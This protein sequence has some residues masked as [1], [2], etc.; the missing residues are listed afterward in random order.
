MNK[1]I[2]NHD[3]LYKLMKFTFGLL[4][5]VLCHSG[6]IYAK[7]DA[8]Y[9]RACKN[10]KDDNLPVAITGKVTD[11]K[12]QPLV[13]VSILIK[14]TNNG[15]VTDIDGK[16]KLNVLNEKAVLLFRYIGYINKEVVVGNASLLNVMLIAEPKSINEIVVVGYST[17]SKHKL[18][19]A[20]VTVSGDELNK[21]VATSP[22]T[23]LQGKLPGLQVVQGSGEPGAE[24]VQLTI[25]GTG[26]FSGA[27]S[28]P[29][30]IVDGLPGSLDVLNAN[31]IESISVLKDASSA[32]I[33]GS[34][35][36]NGVIVV[37][38]KRGKAGS[39]SVQ[40]AYN[41]GISNAT[42]LPDIVTNSATYMQ[43]SNEARTNSS[44]AP[45]YTQAQ[46]D[47]YQNATD[48]V[49]YPNHN[50]LND[51][52]RTAYTQNHYLN[53][54]GGKDSTTY[55]VGIGIT[56]QPGVMRGFDYKKYTLSLGLTSKLNKRITFGSDIQMRYGKKLTPEN[57]AG[58]QFLSALAQ[59]P[60]YPAQ[61][62]GKWIKKAYSN[63]LGNKNPVAIVD[64]DV[65]IRGDDKYLQGNLSL[66][67]DLFKGLRWENKGGF[68]YGT[69]KFNDF[70]PVV[71]MY[72]YSD[73]SPAGSLDVGAPGL[74]VGTSDNLYT[75]YYSQ[76][77]YK[78]SFGAHNFSAFGGYQQEKN[79]ASN[80]NASRT[81][82]VTN[83]L[84][85]LDAGPTDGQTNGGTSSAWA[86][87]S[88]YGSANYDY[89]DK[90]CLA[91]VSVMT[92]HPGYH[93]VPVTEPS[94]H[95][96]VDGEF[97]KKIS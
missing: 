44:L 7:G 70:R 84:R 85:E 96:R 51:I 40:Y 36:A 45:L 30:V 61:V 49:K 60:L 12:G 46:I 72:Y 39:L 10:L 93:P 75:V 19:S 3:V 48:R 2:Q 22:T 16:F 86:I 87:S 82:Y 5:A 29:L 9:N 24:N 89:Q 92:V 11:E 53:M 4:F 63:E 90:Y 43:L 14:G 33:Y 76:L 50:W 79:T 20:V 59:S 27:G 65:R 80:L 13:G 74:N 21:R 66:D 62:D 15:A 37:K 83:F 41:F 67:I 64:E 34:R 1:T 25:R 28:N 69:Y 18:T 52:F 97:Q 78:K 77:T 23:L 42:K 91:R 8:S 38:T 32:A 94:T 31:D 71:P 54:S 56:N 57:G 68:N 35:G 26:T 88:L 17:Q 58:D 81:Q 6:P 95:F 55:S 47:L 73:M